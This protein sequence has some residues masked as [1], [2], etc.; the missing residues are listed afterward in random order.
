MVAIPMTPLNKRNTMIER[1]MF[2]LMCE[3]VNEVLEDRTLIAGQITEMARW[4]C[5]P[6]TLSLLART[7][8]LLLGVCTAA[9]C[10]QR[11]TTYEFSKKK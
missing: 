5:S 2:R 8:C 1:N 4:A 11:C 3:K 7:E 6:A 10:I 9:Y